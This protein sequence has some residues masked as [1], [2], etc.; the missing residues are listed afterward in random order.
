LPS[1]S[2]GEYDL[3]LIIP[4]YNEAERIGRGLQTV[5]AW[6]EQ[7]CITTELIVVDD[8]ST[9]GTAEVVKV[10]VGDSLPLRI[11]RNEPNR[12]KGFSVRR[13]LLEGKGAIVGFSDADFSTPIEEADRLLAAINEEGYDIAIGSRAMKESILAQRQAW[14]REY[15]GRAFSLCYRLVLIPGIVDSQ[16]GFKFLR[17][18]VAHAVLPHQ[19]LEDWAFDAEVLYIARRLGYTIAQIPIRWVNDPSSKVKMLRDGPKMALD[20]WRARWRHRNLRPG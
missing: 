15:A 16:C 3:S 17:R 19:T 9:D 5:I 13:G 18:E 2:A 14:Y 11:L 6:V 1:Q 4:A 20:V 8:G 7:C 10:A 12:G